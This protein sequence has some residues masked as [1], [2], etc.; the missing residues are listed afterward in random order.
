MA[1]SVND[2]DVGPTADEPSHTEKMERLDLT[3]RA[4]K[5]QM[6]EATR[7]S[8]DRANDLTRHIPK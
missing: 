2:P 8:V 5:L 6:L 3:V 4:R 7:K 1:Q